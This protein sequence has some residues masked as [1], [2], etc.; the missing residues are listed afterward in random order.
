MLVFTTQTA[1]VTRGQSLG[2]VV[3]TEQDGSGNTIVD[4]SSSVDFTMAACGGSVD[5]GNIAMVS[6]VATLTSSQRF[7]TLASGWRINAGNGTLSG[8]SQTF[9]VVADADYVLADNFDG[10]RL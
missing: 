3:V 10:C 7:Y 5:L 1:D 8:T 6:G 2:T 4:N 9:N